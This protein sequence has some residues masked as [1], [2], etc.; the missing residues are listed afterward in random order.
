ML[1]QWWN[2][3]ETTATAEA[4]AASE[5]TAATAAA[6]CSKSNHM[7]NIKRQGLAAWIPFGKKG[8]PS[9]IIR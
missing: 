4:T 3:V 9:G 1:V 7:K 2:V 6:T 8:F 5:A